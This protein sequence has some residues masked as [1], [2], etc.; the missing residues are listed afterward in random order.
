[1]DDEIEI[2]LRKYILQLFKHWWQII[3]IAAILAVIAFGITSLSSFSYQ[4]TA[5][6]AVTQPSYQ[7]N[8]DPKIQTV[9]VQPA[10]DVYLD[11]ATSDDLIKQVYDHWKERPESITNLETFRKNILSVAS[12]SDESII[13]LTAKTGSPTQSADLA[14]F[15]AQALIDK[16]NAIY[17]GQ[18]QKLKFLEEQV[19]IAQSDLD[20]ADKALVVFQSQNQLQ[21]L[22]N[23]L[24]SSLQYQKDYLTI[25]RN[26]SYLDQ[27]LQGLRSQLV[28][29]PGDQTT[30][31]NQLN[32]LLLQ[33]Q[34]FNSQ[35]TGSV[36]TIPLQIQLSDTE[37]FGSLDNQEQ[38]KILDNL[39]K[40]IKD[41]DTEV[42]EA[43]IELDP[44]ILSL[45][46][47]VQQ[48]QV[49]F[50][51]LQRSQDIAQQTYTTLTKKVD[52]VRI[53]DQDPSNRL[54]LASSALPPTDPLPRNRLRNT[55]LGGLIGG[56]LA[57]TL[58]LVWEWWREK[59]TPQA[60]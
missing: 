18:D 26:I 48:Y 58:V 6:V 24:N 34:T 9:N 29:N 4:A 20:I 25:Q 56:A 31:A 52:E 28:T 45:Q 49:T 19:K 59:A 30:I 11:L 2:D 35:T 13:K 1:M 32:S 3:L 46:Q 17:F 21:I 22:T 7:L 36:N 51:Q 40:I 37:I 10:N 42:A 8:F 27:S 60:T 43:L 12:G 38:I 54:Q 33:F 44:K 16:T 47:E 41:R 53:S 39:A 5:L 55:I 57:I 50:D 15:W 14:N 23:Q